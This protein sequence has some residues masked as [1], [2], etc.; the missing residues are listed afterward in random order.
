MR[1]GVAVRIPG[2]ST[3]AGSAPIGLRRVVER[4]LASNRIAHGG[5]VVQARTVAPRRERM[6]GGAARSRETED[7]D[8]ATGEAV[9]HDHCRYRN[10]KVA[11]PAIARI[12]AMIQKRITILD[13]SQ[14]ICS[15]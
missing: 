2:D 11:S 13:S 7:R 5:I 9:D 6:R 8:A 4:D 1:L 3:S 10:F 15:K 12:S 14:P